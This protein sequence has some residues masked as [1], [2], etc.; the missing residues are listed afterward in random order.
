MSY[1]D[2]P[3]LAK[4]GFLHGSAAQPSLFLGPSL[5]VNLSANSKLEGQG[6]DIDVD[7]KDQVRALDVGLVVG[8]GVEIPV[9][10]RTYG[11]ELRYSKGLSNAAGEEA[12]G[13]A[14]NDVIAL[15]ASIGLQ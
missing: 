12:N 8:G 14:H 11:V 1:I 9:G 15:M 5:A 4:I 6:A 3:V 7:V 13:T 10:K 2:V